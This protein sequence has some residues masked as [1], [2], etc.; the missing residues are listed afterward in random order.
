MKIKAW[1]LKEGMKIN[2]KGTIYE[3]CQVVQC[4]ITK[5]AIY[6]NNNYNERFRTFLNEKDIEVV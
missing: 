6:V 3:V 1:D 2:F 5:T 4:G